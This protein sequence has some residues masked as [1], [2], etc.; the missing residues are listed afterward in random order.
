VQFSL[1][2]PAI[3]LIPPRILIAYLRVYPNNE[4]ISPNSSLLPFLTRGPYFF[5]ALSRN[6]QRLFE[7]AFEDTPM[8]YFHLSQ[9]MGSFRILSHLARE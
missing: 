7:L 2:P 4:Q 5:R 3:G 6:S 8:A 1:P 9:C